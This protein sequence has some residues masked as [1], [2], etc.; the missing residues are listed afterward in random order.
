LHPKLL[1]IIAVTQNTVEAWR[2]PE[3]DSKGC[4]ERFFPRRA[5]SEA[6]V[7]KA[8]VGLSS[9]TEQCPPAAELLQVPE[10]LPDTAS[11]NQCSF[12]FIGRCF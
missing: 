7:T 11:L 12:N 5:N 6:L 10:I 4:M 8:L 9:S 3:Q 2:H 1:P